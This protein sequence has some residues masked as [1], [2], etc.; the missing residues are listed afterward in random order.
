MRTSREI[1]L[2]VFNAREARKKKKE[3][4]KL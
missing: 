3:K 2:D 1:I 4:N